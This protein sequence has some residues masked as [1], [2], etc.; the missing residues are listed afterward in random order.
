MD[1]RKLMLSLMEGV[2][3][4]VTKSELAANIGC[5]KMTISK[6][7]KYSHTDFT[8]PLWL[9]SVKFLKPE[10]ETEVIAQVGEEWLVD[11][12]L[13]NIRCMMEYSS[14]NRDFH[15]LERFIHAQNSAPAV[16]KDA[17]RTYKIMMDFQQREVSNSD[18]LTRLEKVRPQSSES[19]A[20]VTI[21][22]ALVNY[23]LK[24]YGSMFRLAQIAE[25]Q[26]SK[27]K[28]AYLRD[29]Y[30]ARISEIMARSYLY[31]RNDVRKARF[32][33]NTVVN[34]RYLS[35]NY[36]SHMHHLIGT[37][38]MFEDHAESL[39]W[40]ESYQEILKGGGRHELAQSVVETD[41]FFAKVLHDQPVAADETTDKLELMHYYAK[42]GDFEA[43]ERL[44]EEVPQ[45]DPF[46]MCY[47]GMARHD[48][49]L[50]LK[51]TARFVET[52]NKFFAEL[53]KTAIKLHP[54]YINS[55]KIIRNIKLA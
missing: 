46:A 40:F 51:S 9:L 3:R 47:L 21:M 42:R 4:D 25:E 10:R 22:K 55:A 26:T 53:P 6:F 12:S 5:S 29:S 19:A 43:V 30:M 48:P 54:M 38:F 17:A 18:L 1:K 15:T 49:E 23:R 7:F 2:E 11:G 8:F 24:E 14:I 37:S 34:S 13:L 39:R 32:Y 52:G 31:L 16:N 33:A 20:L 28:N 45:D 41:V 50:M 35:D 44:S 36:K 27:L